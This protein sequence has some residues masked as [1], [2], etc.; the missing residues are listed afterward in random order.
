M[1]LK[2]KILIV[3]D[4]EFFFRKILAD[5]L[6]DRYDIIEAKNGEECIALSA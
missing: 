5:G 6:N 1:T 4:D 2:K 3:V